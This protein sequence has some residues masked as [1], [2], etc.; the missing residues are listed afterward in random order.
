MRTARPGAPIR[1]ST[2]LA[3]R[4]DQGTE[5]DTVVGCFAGEHGNLVAVP[6]AGLT[7]LGAAELLTNDQVLRADNAAVALRLLGQRDR[8]VWYVPDA[9]DL[10]G[11]DG[12]T[13]STLLP[14]VDPPGAVGAR[15]GRGRAAAVAGQAARPAG[16]RAAAG[17]RQGDR[18]RP[19][20]GSPLPQVGRP[21]ACGPG[22]AASRPRLDGRAAAPARP[23][24]RRPGR[25]GARR[26]PGTSTGRSSRCTPCS[27]TTAR[28][29]RPT[30]N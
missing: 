4:V 8:L 25:A 20:P 18:D 13:L 17:D 26:R 3:V 29:P 23:G 1:C 6:R 15:R 11:D 16:D 21:R 9:A 5:Y 14:R 19:Q 30:P 10:V 7:F 12:V 28:S 2:G 27:P 24:H 22:P